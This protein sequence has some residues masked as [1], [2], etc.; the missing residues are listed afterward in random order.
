[1][2]ATFEGR[3]GFA[4]RVIVV[5]SLLFAACRTDDSTAP[6]NTPAQRIISLVPAVTEM[7]FAIGAG[8]DVV[9]VSSFDEYPAEVA[10]LPRVGALIDPDFERILT[11]RPTLVVVYESQTDLIARLERASIGMFPY[12]HSVGAG[13]GEITE[14]MRRLGTRTGHADTAAATADRIEQEID[15]VRSRVAGRA[16]PSTVVVFGREPGTLRGIY[17]SGGVGFLHDLLVAAGGEN[18]FADVRRE[19]LQASVETLLSRAPEVILELRTSDSAADPVAGR[20]AWNRLASMPAVRD[21]RIHV[22]TDPSLS[23]PGP[24]IAAAAR[25]FAAVLQPGS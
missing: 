9:A 11:L 22:L 2:T 17:V 3:A 21:G 19:N 7:L 6:P 24:R 23:I 10:N 12:R 15:L 1:M 16:R 4:V 14:T 8:D 25:A 13:L 5:C 20:D 18:V